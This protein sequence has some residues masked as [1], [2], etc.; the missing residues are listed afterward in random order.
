M[1]PR[2]ARPCRYNPATNR[3]H[4]H[5]NESRRIPGPFAPTRFLLP[6]SNIPLSRAAHSTQ[7]AAHSIRTAN[8]GACRMWWGHHGQPYLEPY[9]EAADSRTSW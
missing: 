4:A 7:R 8:N 1:Q 5:T 3:L 9:E 2:A 6:R